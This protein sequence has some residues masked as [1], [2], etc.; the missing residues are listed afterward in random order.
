MKIITLTL[1]PAYDVHCFTENFQPFHENLAR[2]TSGEVGG[3]GINISRALTVNGIEN[4][5]VVIVGDENGRE[6]LTGLEKDG[7]RYKSLTVPGR[8]RENFTLHSEG[9]PETRISFAGFSVDDS[10]MDEVEKL[11]QNNDLT[12]AVLTFTG[13]LPNGLSLTRAKQFL[14]ALQAAGAKLVLDSKSFGK[15]DVLQVRPWLIKPNEEEIALYTDLPVTDRES[16]AEAAKKLRAQGVENVM[17]SLGAQ[18][19]VLCCSEGVFFAPAPTV[20]AISTIG[21]GDSTIA[22]FIAAVSGGASYADALQQAVAYGSAS[23]L[24]PGTQ[25]PRPADIRRL[26]TQ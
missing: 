19:A 13:R 1:N 14:L 20:N 2:I 23:C 15:E 12:D 21:A 3:K 26:L 9:Q 22:G 8:I 4:T 6:F 17:I 16:A 7:I 5:A 10:V 18:G 25:P 11:L 24:T